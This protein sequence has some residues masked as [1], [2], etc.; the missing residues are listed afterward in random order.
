MPTVAKCRQGA[1]RGV[2]KHGSE[3]VSG[4]GNGGSIGARVRDD[5]QE[6]AEP[7]IAQLEREAAEEC[8]DV[9]QPRLR[10]HGQAGATRRLIGEA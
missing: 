3:E 2:R 7:G 9:M 10:I 1:S 8:L 5:E 6:V 4:S